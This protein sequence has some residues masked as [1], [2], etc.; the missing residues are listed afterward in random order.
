[1]QVPSIPSRVCQAH[2]CRRAFQH[3]TPCSTFNLTTLLPP[4]LLPVTFGSKRFP[5]PTLNIPFRF[6][7]LTPKQLIAPP[8]C[9]NL[10]FNPRVSTS[11]KKA[12]RWLNGVQLNRPPGAM[13]RR[14]TQPSFRSQLKSLSIPPLPMT[15]STRRRCGEFARTKSR[16]K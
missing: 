3:L 5:R 14:T 12:S 7:P 8:L 13:V 2:G 4:F 15:T 10:S 11:P 1:M 16:S 9:H 6:S